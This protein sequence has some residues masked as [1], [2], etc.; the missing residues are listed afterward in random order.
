MREAHRCRTQWPAPSGFTM[1]EIIVALVIVSVMAVVAIPSFGN[2][3]TNRRAEN[4]RNDLVYVASR[5]Q[6]AAVARGEMVRLSMDPSMDRLTLLAASGDTLEVLDMKA[7]DDADL[8]IP[9]G[10]LHVCYSPLGF[11]H[12]SCS[13]VSDNIGVKVGGSTLWSTLSATG[14]VRPK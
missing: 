11:A 6:M 5:A 3:L 10:T 14:A 1:L 2:S 12:P 13:E 9:T 8:L 7:R 4:A